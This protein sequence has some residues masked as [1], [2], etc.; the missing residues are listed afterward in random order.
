MGIVVWQGIW[1]GVR[2]EQGRVDVRVVNHKSVSDA[3]R[4]LESVAEWVV[5]VVLDLG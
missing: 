1:Q 3:R 2:M 4:W 5:M